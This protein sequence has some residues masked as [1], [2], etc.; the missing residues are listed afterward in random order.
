MTGSSPRKV[1]TVFSSKWFS[2]EAHYNANCGTEGEGQPFYKVK[3][4]DGVVVL[5]ITTDNRYV[6]IRQYRP[7]LGRF[8]IEIPAGAVENG[9][10]PETAATREVYE[11]TGYRCTNFQL[12]G[13]GVLRI[14]REDSCNHY[15]VAT[16]A[17]EESDF[18]AKEE[19]FPFTVTPDEFQSMVVN[20]AFDH[21][22][23]LPLFVMGAWSFRM[24]FGLSNVMKVK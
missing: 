11:E 21:T 1:E 18:R 5:P 12:L 14:D 4:A 15:F 23:A 13:S 24:D 6:L 20:G 17:V 22:A 19:I 8:T 9:E 7:A 16:G 3:L 2:V 10:A